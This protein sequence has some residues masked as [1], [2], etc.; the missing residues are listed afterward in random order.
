[1]QSNINYSWKRRMQL[2]Q[3]SWK[4]LRGD[5][6]KLLQVFTSSVPHIS[7]TAVSQTRKLSKPYRRWLGWMSV[8]TSI[9]T[10]DQMILR[11]F[12]IQLDFWYPHVVVAPFFSPTFL[13]FLE[14]S[15]GKMHRRNP[16]PSPPDSKG[17]LKN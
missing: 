8:F 11:S 17:G 14:F 4:S 9:L 16:T 6:Y 10:L 2:A 7:R 12:S 15:K 5:T 13:C 3:S 1:M